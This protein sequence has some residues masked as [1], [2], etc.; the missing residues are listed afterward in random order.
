M[1]RLFETDDSWLW[2]MQRLVL[3]VVFFAHGAQ[4]A[5]GW[6]GGPGL[7]RTL[8][9]LES[10]G[11]PPLI[12]VL[13]ILAQFLGSLCLIVGFFTRVAALGIS[14][15]MLGAIALVH[16]RVGFFMNWTGTLRGEGFEFHLLALALSVSLMVAG[17]GAWSIDGLLAHPH[18]RRVQPA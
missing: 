2:T 8:R 7:H 12:A 11:M 5:L 3:G 15:V 14:A 18:I 17:A 10:G 1:R 4:M 13:V 16:S 6:F 9:A